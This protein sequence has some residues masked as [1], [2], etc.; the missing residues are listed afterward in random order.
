MITGWVDTMGE[1]GNQIGAAVK[2]PCGI[3]I[4]R[5]RRH[6]PAGNGCDTGTLRG[7]HRRRKRCA[8]LGQPV[9][10]PFR[11]PESW[12]DLGTLL[13]SV[14][15]EDLDIDTQAGT[16]SDGLGPVA[17]FRPRL[18][19]PGLAVA[20]RENLARGPDLA[21]AGWVQLDARVNGVL[22]APNRARLSMEDA[23]TRVDGGVGGAVV[24][25]LS[26]LPA[27]CQSGGTG[28]GGV[29]QYPGCAGRDPGATTCRARR[30]SG[31][32][33]AHKQSRL[34]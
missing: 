33:R 10:R 4:R 20:M 2:R 8:G 18:G 29:E 19:H 11:D 24:G 34:P 5:P 12:D 25:L 3:Q 23:E 14:A 32:H 6:P 26:P 31:V 15:V 16:V 30:S 1:P 21:R 13:S 22:T 9:E 28:A 17:G 7:S 27:R